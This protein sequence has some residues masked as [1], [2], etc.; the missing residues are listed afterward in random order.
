M[1]QRAAAVINIRHINHFLLLKLNN[2]HLSLSVYP[3]IYIFWSFW[4]NMGE[5][6]F[7]L[8][9][10]KQRRGFAMITLFFQDTRF[11]RLRPP[12]RVRYPLKFLQ[13]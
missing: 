9:Y 1:A 2:M 3:T 8:L 7:R 6:Q 11:V 10:L 12:L 5:K 13:A 4:N